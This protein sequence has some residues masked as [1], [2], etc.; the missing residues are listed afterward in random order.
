MR[1]IALQFICQTFSSF[2][3]KVHFD[4]E[5]QVMILSGPTK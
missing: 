4:R 5:T 3:K 1:I 2:I